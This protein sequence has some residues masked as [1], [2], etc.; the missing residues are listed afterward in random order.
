MNIFML[1][2][3]ILFA[4][5]VYGIVVSRNIARILLSIEIMFNAVILYLLSLV[6]SLAVSYYDTSAIASLVIFAI[7][8]AV[9]EIVVTFSILLA[10]IRFK[11]L[12]RIDTEE[13]IIRDLK[14]D[15]S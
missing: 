2:A 7:G 11:V 14:G 15:K 12:R 5:S 10:L 6:V 3:S 4:V 13:I 9:S 1:V 8:L